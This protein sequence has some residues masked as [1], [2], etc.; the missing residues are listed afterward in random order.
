MI[1]RWQMPLVALASMVLLLAAASARADCVDINAD[2]AER[3]TSIAHE[4][5]ERAVQFIA[6]R[7]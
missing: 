4:S 2:P 1:R 7:P 3:L 6:G 5:D